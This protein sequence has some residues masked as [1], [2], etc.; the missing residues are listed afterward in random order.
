[1]R[2][3]ST[4][5]IGNDSREEITRNSYRAIGGTEEHHTAGLRTTVL[6]DGD[7]TSVTGSSYTHTSVTHVIQ[8]GDQVHIKSGAN[9]IL[10]A[11]ATLTLKGGGQHIVLNADG[12]FSSVLIEEGGEPMWGINAIKERLDELIPSESKP[13]A[14]VRFSG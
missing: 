14:S 8:A 3:D 11:G 9:V 12:I 1:I 10:D 7:R 2:N 13:T 4:A 6:G 5:T